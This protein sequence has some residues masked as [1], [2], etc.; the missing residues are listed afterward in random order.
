MSTQNSLTSLTSSKTALTGQEE[1]IN[2]LETGLIICNAQGQ[3]LLWNQWMVRITGIEEAQALDASLMKL[4]NPAPATTLLDAIDQACNDRLSR[5]LSYQL[6]PDLLPLK[7][8]NASSPLQ[9]SIL[10]RP[11]EFAGEA[12]C[13][14]QINDVSSTVRREHHLREAEALLRL[15]REILSLVAHNQPIQEIWQALYQ[16]M[17]KLAPEAKAGILLLDTEGKKLYNPLPS[18]HNLF[19]QELSLQAQLPPA[20]TYVQG[21][22]QKYQQAQGD[23]SHWW[24]HPLLTPDNQLT[25]VIQL[26]W[27]SQQEQPTSSSALLERSAQ[28]AAL[29]LQNHRQLLQV[30]YLAEHDSLT[31]L[32]NRS[33]LTQKLQELCQTGDKQPFALLFIDLDGFKDTNDRHGHDAGD[34]L[35]VELAKRLEQHLPRQDQAARLGGD[36]LVVISRSTQTQNAAFTLAR[37]LGLILSQPF[38]WRDLTLQAGASIGIALFPEEGQTPNS[39]LTRADNAMY[40]AKSRGKGQAASCDLPGVVYNNSNSH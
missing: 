9:H 29:A 18:N 20:L 8:L 12:A 16:G 35:L 31:G 33:L 2:L 36:E 25:G 27:P 11:L 24:C 23:W 10:V 32:A 4:F 3:I 39:L 1:V 13:L 17:E 34:A 6:H 30:R 21:Q 40:L 15:E 28:L 19:P 38:S 7:Q 26:V 5:R 14:L 37:E 22:T